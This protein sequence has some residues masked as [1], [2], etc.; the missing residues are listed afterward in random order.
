MEFIVII[1]ARYASSRL[2]A[3]PLADIAGKPMVQHVYEKA[4]ASGAS[5]VVVATDHSVIFDAVK[6]FNGEVV[7]TDKDHSSGTERLAEVV[8][9]LALPDDA[10]VVNVQGDEPLIPPEN[11]LQVAQ[12]LAHDEAPMATLSVAI[13]EVDEVFNPNAVKVVADKLNNA[14]YFSRATIPYD[15]ER[16]IKQSDIAEI[17]PYYQ[18]HIGIYAYRA[19]FINDYIAMDV[20]PLEQIES[21]EQLRVLYHGYKIK[22][23]TAKIEPHPGVDTPEDLVK[24]NAYLDEN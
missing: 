14:I 2:P 17:G 8:Q 4:I 1:P 6:A 5:R 21:L 19:G 9:K 24:I 11:I 10:I 20:S 16:F 23:Q 22:V 15:R 3:K 7:M 18:R 13:K 12:L